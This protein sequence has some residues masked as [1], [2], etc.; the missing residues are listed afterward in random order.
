MSNL[1]IKF[2]RKDSLGNSV[3]V[4]TE[5]V[6]NE[7]EADFILEREEGHYDYVA[8]EDIRRK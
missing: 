1:I 2:Y 7:F 4:R 6:S 5:E 3:L 8:I